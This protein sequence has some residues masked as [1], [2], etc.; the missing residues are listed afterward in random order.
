[1]TA[2]TPTPGTTGQTRRI[3]V[4]VDGSASSLDA[5][6]YA[7]R[8]APLTGSQIEA[9]IAWQYP[10]P[11]G[12]AVP[13]WDPEAEARKVLI[14]S[15]DEA[16]GADRPD[17]M[18]LVVREGNPAKVLIEAGAGATM[19]VV[20]SRGRGGFAGLRLGSVS[21]HCAEHATCPVLVLH[22]GDSTA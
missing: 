19:L 22:D 7:A 13:D 20:G 1:M 10:V 9:V 8:L 18:A 12:W 17:G 11:I 16:Y 15:V 5:L 21:A 3:V 2:T 4:G 14:A 6:R